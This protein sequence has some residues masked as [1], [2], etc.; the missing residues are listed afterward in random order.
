MV[1]KFQNA[2]EARMDCNTVKSNSTKCAQYLTHLPFAPYSRFPTELA[3]SLLL[4]FSLFALVA[5]LSQFLC[6]ESPY[7]SIKLHRIYVCYMNIM[8]D[9]HIALGIIHSFT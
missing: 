3:S 1:H 2:H 5:A 8:L 7:L 6:S 9:T 4:A